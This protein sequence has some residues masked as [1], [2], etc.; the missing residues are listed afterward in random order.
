MVHEAVFLVE[1]ALW[2]IELSGVARG[3]KEEYTVSGHGLVC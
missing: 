3:K 1:P 2:L